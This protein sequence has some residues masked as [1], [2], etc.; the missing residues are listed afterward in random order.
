MRRNQSTLAVK[1]RSTAVDGDSRS[2]MFA[3]VGNLCAL[4]EY[5]IDKSRSAVGRITSFTHLGR[6]VPSFLARRKLET[7]FPRN[8]NHLL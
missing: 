3:A 5:R 8:D 2:R 1:T 7:R 6:E 4:V